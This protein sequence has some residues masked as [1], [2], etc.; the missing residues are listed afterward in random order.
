MAFDRLADST[1]VDLLYV[2]SIGFLIVLTLAIVSSIVT[3]N[4]SK[5]GCL[6]REIRAQSSATNPVVTISH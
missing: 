4:R 1:E 3:Y 6:I 2:T 5:L